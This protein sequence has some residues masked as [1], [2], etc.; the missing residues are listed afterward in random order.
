[1]PD[2]AE[3]RDGGRGH[4]VGQEERREHEP[5]LQHLGLE[6]EADQHAGP[7]QRAQTA[8]LAGPDGGVGRQHEQQDEQGVR[9]VA[10]V[11]QDHDRAGRH[12]HG[13]D[14]PGAGTGHPAD[15][16][17]EDEHGEHAFD[18]LG[19][20]QRPHVEAEDAQRQGLYP[21]RTREFVDRDRGPGVGRA[22]EE[23][24][25]VHRHAAR[26]AAVEGLDVDLVDAPGVG[27]A[28]QRGD[29]QQRRAGPHRLVGGGA[30]ETEGVGDQGG[31][32]SRRRR[33]RR[34]SCVPVLCVC[35]AR[36]RRSPWP[37]RR[38]CSAGAGRWPWTECQATTSIRSPARRAGRRAD[39]H[40]RRNGGPS[41]RR[42][43]HRGRRRRGR[44]SAA[45]LRGARSGGDRRRREA[46]RPAR[47]G[48]P[49]WSS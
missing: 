42:R 34:G 20:D 39:G 37:P 13:G 30:P 45:V 33:G 25:Q 8:R 32:A 9:D 27:E 28:G 17:V 24:V 2:P 22:V 41:R 40:R 15:R 7:E 3:E 5:G 6:G 46:P 35:A 31:A 29:D 36:L 48:P 1:M 38:E 23:V 47:R 21:E 11:E 12:D 18:H 19:E 14:E 16:A 49:P 26:R 4:Q 10:A 44:L 43:T